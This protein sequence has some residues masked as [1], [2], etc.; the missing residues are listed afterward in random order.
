MDFFQQRWGLGPRCGNASGAKR[1]V[2]EVWGQC[3]RQTPEWQ[4]EWY[5]FATPICRYNRSCRSV[6]SILLRKI[7]ESD[8]AGTWACGRLPLVTILY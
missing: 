3:N 6:H 7:N 5:I 2:A 8:P 1:K 4:A